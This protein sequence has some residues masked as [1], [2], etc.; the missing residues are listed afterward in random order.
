M[1]KTQQ[2]FTLIE[3]I[4]VIVIIGILA[5]VAM[6]RFYDMQTDARAAKAEALFGSIRSASAITHSAAILRSATGATGTV[7]MEGM[8]IALAYGYPT[9]GSIASAANIDPNSDNITKVDG[10][11]SVQFQ[12]GG[13]AVPASCAITYTEATSTAGAQITLKH[14]TDD[15]GDCS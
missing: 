7:S 10:T 2:G 4:M 13:A 15:G 3:L 6:P 5:S 9:I 8:A 11:G 12:I 1:R 14:K